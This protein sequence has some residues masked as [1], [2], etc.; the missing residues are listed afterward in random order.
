VSKTYR[1]A[2]VAY[3]AHYLEPEER[4]ELA[5]LRETGLSVRQVAARLGRSPSTVSRELARNADPATGGYAPERAHRLAWERQR[6]PRPSKLSQDPRLCAVVQQ[7]L[8]RRYKLLTDEQKRVATTPES[9]TFKRSMAPGIPSRS[10]RMIFSSALLN[11]Q[12]RATIKCKSVHL[13]VGQHWQ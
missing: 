9:R 2:G 10:A 4:Y 5:R 6:R 13:A 7:L 11:N 3:S 1:P 8:D 12:L